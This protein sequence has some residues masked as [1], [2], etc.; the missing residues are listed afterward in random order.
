MKNLL[1]LILACAAS[2]HSYAQSKTE[3]VTTFLA[4]SVENAKGAYLRAQVDEVTAMVK[5][6][7][8]AAA[9]QR[10][11]ELRKA[12]EAAFDP[13]LKQYTFQLREEFLEFGNSSASQFEW[14]D[15]GY[16]DCLQMQAFIAAERRDFPAALAILKDLE[17]IA[18]VSAGT[19]TEIGYVLNQLGRHEEGLSAYRRAHALS[20]RYVSQ[21]PYRAVALRGIGFSLIELKQFAEAERAFFESLEIEPGNKV[22]LSELA[23]I[24]DLRDSK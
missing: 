6:R 4:L 20:V 3:T 18:P 16:K 9:D 7:R 8:F 24:R 21:R 15:W 17:P 1:L 14:I 12:Y 11:G 10:A 13:S 23:Y 22:A 19:S 5:A 2:L